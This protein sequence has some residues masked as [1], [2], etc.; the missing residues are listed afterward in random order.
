MIVL[1]LIG[2]GLIRIAIA[3]VDLGIIRLRCR[4]G[5]LRRREKR[6]GAECGC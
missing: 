1:L 5:S 4:V 6:R 2:G 3:L